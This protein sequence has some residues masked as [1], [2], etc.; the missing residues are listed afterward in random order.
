MAQLP[1]TEEQLIERFGPHLNRE[2]P[3]GWNAG[4]EVEREV[5]N[6]CSCCGQQ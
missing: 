6:H 1:V 2:L 4:W 3:G 5:E